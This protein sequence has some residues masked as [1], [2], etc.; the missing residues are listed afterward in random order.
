[1]KEQYY[2]IKHPFWW[3]ESILNTHAILFFSTNKIVGF[4][5]L[6]ASFVNPIAGIAGLLGLL[7]ANVF[8][9]LIGLN[10]ES[11]RKGYYGFDAMLVAFG[12]V[13]TFELNLI[14]V[15]VIFCVG[16]LSVLIGNFIHA[17]LHKY[18]LPSLSIPFVFTAW[19]VLS[20]STEM[21]ALDVHHHILYPLNTL[22]P[23]SGNTIS[24]WLL[25]LNQ[26]DTVFSGIPSFFRI[27]LKSLGALFFLPNLLS[28]TLMAIALIVYSRIAFSLSLLG[29]F[30]G[31]FCYSFFG[32]NLADLSTNFVGL[33][34]IFL[35]I[36]IGGIYLVP[37]FVSYLLSMVLMPIMILLFFGLNRILTPLDLP[38]YSLPFSLI[39]VL[40]LYILY[41][42]IRVS[43]IHKVIYQ[44]HSPEKNLAAHLNS[45]NRLRQF[46]YIPIHLPFWGEWMVSQ[47]HD[48]KITHLGDWSKA[49]D[50]I[51]LDEE[52]KSYEQ[53]GTN[54]TDFYCFN[55]PVVA[56]ADGYVSSIV[57]HVDDNEIRGVNTLQNWGNSIVIFHVDGLYSQL[58]HLKKGSIKV[59]VGDF[60]KRGEIV[61]Y[62]G[63]SGRSPEPHIHFQLQATPLIGEK[64]RSYPLAY[65]LLN[66]HKE[67]KLKTFDI[68]QEGQLIQTIDVN[69]LLKSAFDFIPGKKFH[70]DI[71]DEG[72]ISGSE[73]WEIFTDAYNLT[74]LYCS[75][76]K[77]YA[78]FYNDGNMLIFTSFIGDKSG[79][80]HHFYLAHYK[81]IFG[82]YKGLIIEEQYPMDTLSIKFLQVLQ[83]FIAP[84]YQFFKTHYSM[85][86]ANIDDANLSNQ[87]TLE[88]K[89]EIRI[90]GIKQ[91]AFEYNTVLKDSQL[92]EFYVFG[93]HLSLKAVCVIS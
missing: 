62:C 30:V 8:S 1:M 88:S 38:V 3:I 78:Y 26:L 16:F 50:F 72:V 63:N 4:I 23:S 54:L 51:V 64:T 7:S 42:R 19:I 87:I 32:G 40:F 76:S 58:S 55:K 9:L 12:L 56:C 18:L 92:Y 85:C 20:A 43:Y 36:A 28:G 21:T 53:S 31:Y 82:F 60:V 48:G 37:S 35:S 6:I 67:W 57:D 25:F 34:F 79:L 44:L 47:A 11:I 29:F 68:P 83:D 22:H 13:Y 5:F 33:S 59:A 24:D 77:S 80:L 41:Y 65:Y 14:L 39:V 81:L 73:N 89:A 93:K 74:F 90:G 91:K 52:M 84:F 49:F 69:P 86:Y 66:E 71:Y 27:Y 45:N 10:T 61:G 75:E 15:A 17:V 46:N 70:F 2:S